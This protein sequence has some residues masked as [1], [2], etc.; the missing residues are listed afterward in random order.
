MSPANL[1]ALWRPLWYSSLRQPTPGMSHWRHSVHVCGMKIAALNKGCRKAWHCFAPAG[2]LSYVCLVTTNSREFLLEVKVEVQRWIS[3]R[4]N[5]VSKRH[6][7]QHSQAI[8]CS[9]GIDWHFLV[10]WQWTWGLPEWVGAT[11]CRDG[12]IMN[13]SDHAAGSLPSAAFLPGGP[14]RG[15]RNRW[16]PHTCSRAS[17]SVSG[18]AGKCWQWA[19]SF[20]CSAIYPT[21]KDSL[22]PNDQPLGQLPLRHVPVA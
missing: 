5:E 21:G 7:L 20:L 8:D 15:S 12:W 17:T 13:T 2:L 6:W 18:A 14:W 10:T 1:R 19:L 4:K 3:F 16:A 9:G 11:L 22:C